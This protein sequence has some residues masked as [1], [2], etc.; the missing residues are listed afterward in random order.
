MD[1]TDTMD[2]RVL[3][4]LSKPPIAI[5]FFDAPPNGVPAWTDGPLASGCSF[6]RKAQEGRTFYTVAADHYNC[7]IGAYTH[8]IS[9]PEGRADE[10]RQTLEF[11][12]ENDY[13]QMEEVPG[14]PM[15][16]RTPNVIAFGP[17]Q[18]VSFA[19]D[20]VVVAAEPAKAMLLYEAALKAGAGGALMNVLGRPAC[21]I[22]PLT[23]QSRSAALSLGCKGNRTYTGLPDGEMYVSIPGD[24]WPAVVQQVAAVISANRAVG[25]YH[26]A[27][28]VQFLTA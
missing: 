20:I 15:L 26:A 21:A 18:S 3:L 23:L 24:K 7:A 6:W 10:L 8:N 16:E 19:P 28:K 13:V 17:V 4:G 11:L 14:I 22:L 5:G 12:G 25:D 1:T 2:L 9:L 27:R